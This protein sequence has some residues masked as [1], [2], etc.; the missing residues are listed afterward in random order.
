MTY[1]KYYFIVY[2][3]IQLFFLYGEI[4]SI[5][6]TY[7]GPKA[8]IRDTQREI[9]SFIAKE[10]EKCKIKTS[11]YAPL[12]RA[13]QELDDSALKTN[14]T[15]NPHAITNT[16]QEGNTLLMA[17]M[18]SLPKK[19]D[20][21]T[22]EQLEKAVAIVNTL[23]KAGVEINRR[24]N[25]GDT[26]LTSLMS[27]FPVSFGEI[28]TDQLHDDYNLM[29]DIINKLLSA[30]ADVNTQNKQDQTPLLLALRLPDQLRNP[31][32]TKLL[33]R[34]ANPD[35]ADSQGNTP[36]IIAAQYQLSRKLDI[37]VFKQLAKVSKVNQQNK[38]GD[39]ALMAMLKELKTNFISSHI[40]PGEYE[41]TLKYVLEY[42][43]VLL[44]FGTEVN[45]KNNDGDT[46]LTLIM[47]ITF[48]DNVQ[49]VEDIGAYQK[50]MPKIVDK[51]LDAGAYVTIKNN[52]NQ[53]P[54]SLAEQL[55]Q[56]YVRDIL[57]N[58]LRARQGQ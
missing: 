9:S 13:A 57:V 19:F 30:Q 22:R 56:Q 35:V 8:D 24:N 2:I 52:R 32:L 58:K 1:K 43:D 34:S 51:L 49:Y 47:M 16:D 44:E 38:A 42:T 37:D 27:I 18:R 26:A 48:T 54:L 21:T 29:E 11:S 41:S 12:F 33:Q 20:M 6:V 55:P 3:F 50:F 36:L 15:A 28:N 46:A 17:V 40:N 31:T 53:T 39:T 14:L 5:D 4:S 45:R 23:L 25:D 10:Y 7:V